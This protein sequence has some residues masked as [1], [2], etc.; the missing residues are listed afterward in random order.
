MSKRSNPNP[1]LSTD[2]AHAG[3][4]DI[5]SENKPSVQPIYQTAVYEFADLTQ[6]DEIWD[7]LK[8]GFIYG[9]YGSPN[10]TSLET[11]VAKLEGA[12]SA[13]ASASGMASITLSLLSFLEAGDEV[14]VANDCYGGSVS[15]AAQDFRRF[16]ITTRFVSTAN[17]NEIETAFTSK[18]KAMLVE[19][20][21]NPLWN[22][23]DVADVAALCHRRGAKLIVDNTVATPYLVR[24][25]AAG[26]DAVVHSATK[27]LAGHDDV[28]AGVLAGSTNFIRRARE[29]AICM[30]PSLS[31][32][33]AWLTVRG[34]KTFALRIERTCS[35]ALAVAKYLK[36]HSAVQNVYYPGLQTHPQHEIV[37]RTMR[38]IGGGMLSFELKGG[39]GAAGKFLK[40][41]RLIRFAPT[42]GGVATTISHPASTSHR[43]LTADQRREAGIT[44]S[45]LRLSIGIE[46]PEDL[47]LELQRALQTI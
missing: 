14:I 34:I 46:E 32:F 18:T 4:E 6:V 2:C 30:G 21:S 5:P 17:R 19:T 42:L 26:A 3:G 9:R 43:A 13:L 44:D 12:E 25:L 38:G 7:G 27:F 37:R 45:L 28:V 47:A 39:S 33:D 41:L 35:N 10:H 22:V 23:V 8:P 29:T 24:P 36:E 11:I 31:P 20:L 1:N 16:G 15:L 40:N